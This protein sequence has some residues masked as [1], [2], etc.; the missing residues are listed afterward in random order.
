MRICA[1]LP[2]LAS[3]LPSLV[4]AIELIGALYT[5]RKYLQTVLFVCTNSWL[6]GQD[7]PSGQAPN[8][9]YLQSKWDTSGAALAEREKSTTARGISAAGGIAVEESSMV[10]IVLSS[11]SATFVKLPLLF[12]I[13]GLI[14]KGSIQSIIFSSSST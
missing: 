1:R 2:Q 6:K 7:S 5:L 10:E 8:I 3:P 13:V 12:L 9:W 11:E 14:R 4:D